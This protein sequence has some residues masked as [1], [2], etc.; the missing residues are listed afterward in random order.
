MLKIPTFS[1]ITDYY[2]SKGI[3]EVS[4]FS[5][6]GVQP[7]LPLLNYMYLGNR[8]E[9]KRESELIPI[10]DC[11]YRNM[12]RLALKNYLAYLGQLLIRGL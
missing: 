2:S 10:N 6:P 4:N 7:N 12:Y 1:Q 11:F 8:K 9:L 3:V 5:L